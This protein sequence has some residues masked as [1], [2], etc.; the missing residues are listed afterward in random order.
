MSG[1]KNGCSWEMLSKLFQEC[2]KSAMNDNHRGKMSFVH[3]QRGRG[4]D[5]QASSSGYEGIR[6]NAPHGAKT[7]KLQCGARYKIKF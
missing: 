3:Q 1:K 7:W 4:D 2:P 5:H 6:G